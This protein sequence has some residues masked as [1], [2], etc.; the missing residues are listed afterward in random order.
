MGASLLAL[1]KSIY[2][3]ISMQTKNRGNYNQI[4]FKMKVVGWAFY[5][6]RINAV[7]CE[8]KSLATGLTFEKNLC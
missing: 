3:L 4:A 8:Y 1:A 5:F 7:S 2:Y 6:K